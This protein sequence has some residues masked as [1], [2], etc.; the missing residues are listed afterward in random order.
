[1]FKLFFRKQ[2]FKSLS[3]TDKKIQLEI[4]FALDDLKS[5]KFENLH[6]KKIAGAESSY[7]I[8]IGRWRILFAMYSKEKRIEIIDIFLKKGE[9]DYKKRRGLLV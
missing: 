2:A 9:E 8:R 7:R 3:R 6:L 5:E 4:N 1:M